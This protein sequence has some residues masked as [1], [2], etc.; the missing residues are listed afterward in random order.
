VRC[1]TS[2]LHDEHL[3]KW[4]SSLGVALSTHHFEMGPG[5]KSR[6]SLHIM[7]TLLLPYK[8]GFLNSGIG[9][10]EA[11]IKQIFKSFVM[12]APCQLVNSHRRF[13]RS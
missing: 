2:F 5:E 13:Y 11:E 7:E 9:G 12:C 8:Y 3:F 10:G 1:I 6:C 4:F